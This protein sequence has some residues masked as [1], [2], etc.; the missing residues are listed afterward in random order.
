MKN[1]MAS[2]EYASNYRPDEDLFI[3][4]LVSEINDSFGN[5]H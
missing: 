5:H 1:A 3:S 4:Q 2:P